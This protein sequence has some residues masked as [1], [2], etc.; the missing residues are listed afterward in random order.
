[1]RIAFFSATMLAASTIFAATPIDG[2]YGG[3]LGGY[4]YMPDN[5]STSRYGFLRDRATYTSGYHAG[6]NL[7][8]KSTPLRYEAEVTYISADL[9][10]YHIN[11]IRQIGVDGETTATLAMANVYYDFP[12]MVP[13]VEPFI[14]AGLGYAWVDTNLWSRGPN[15]GLTHYVGSNSVFAYQAT[16]GLTYNFTDNYSLNIA[17]RYVG[18]ERPDHLGKVFQANLA[19]IGATYRFDGD[20]Y[21]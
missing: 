20:R 18:T 4:T 2:W 19:T 7:G 1:M 6:I 10:K 11:H 21:K 17:Y 5:I 9:S 15:V 14:G 13:C 16:A 12:A 8:F 3:V